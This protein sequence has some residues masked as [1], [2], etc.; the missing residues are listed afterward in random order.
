MKFTDL[1]EVSNIIK[2]NSIVA[3]GGF[4]I[5]RKPLAIIKEIANSNIAG[6]H[7]YLLAG[8]LEVDYLVEKSKVKKISAAY[9]GYE[10]LG[11][12]KITRNA[13]ETGKVY[14]EDLTEILYYFR[15]KAGA[16]NIPFFLTDSI[17]NTDI[18]KINSACEKVSDS[19][20][21]VKCK[22]NSINPDFCIIHAQKADRYGNVFINEPDFSEKEM[23]R[24]SKIR[25][26][27]VEE[28]GEL[29]SEEITISK[30]FVDYIIISKKGAYPTGCKG[31]YEPDIKEIINYLEN[32][33]NI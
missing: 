7:L 6:L 24:A 22:I 3:I 15:L 33:Q 16:E 2:S 10:G 32:E 21:K 5:N 28:I 29:K 1:S 17:V 30:E 25:I 31:H 19:M 12:S 27:S 18:I 13:V 11:S 26:F 20:G 23:A 4:T 8:S 14:F 9:V